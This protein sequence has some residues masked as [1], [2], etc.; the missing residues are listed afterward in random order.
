M[1]DKLL[2]VLG[3]IAFVALLTTLA[4]IA[5]RHE[6]RREQADDTAPGRLDDVLPATEPE[7]V[8]HQGADERW[9]P[10]AAV[11]REIPAGDPF[12]RELT[13]IELDG[14]PLFAE[15]W[16]SRERETDL[17]WTPPTFTAEW[18]RLGKD[19][20]RLGQTQPLPR[21]EVPA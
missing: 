19:L 13:D 17:D 6:R 8:E 20:D 1:N 9:S 18:S 16:R 7:P 14:A 2:A 11:A 15:V 4:V 12:T 10:A 5:Y 21:I 3:L